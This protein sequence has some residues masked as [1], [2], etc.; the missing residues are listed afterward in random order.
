MVEK[1]ERKNHGEWNPEGELLVNRHIRKSIQEEKTGNRDC[2]SGGVIDVNGAH[3]IALFAFELQ[4]AVETMAVH[5]ERASI[6]RTRVAAGASETN[7]G[8]QH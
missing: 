1:Q 6:Q 2:H 5:G 8:P 7:A 4:A 3:E